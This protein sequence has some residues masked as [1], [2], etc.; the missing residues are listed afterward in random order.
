LDAL[1]SIRAGPAGAAVAIDVELVC[2]IHPYQFYLKLS[3]NPY[4]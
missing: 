1:S 4:P 3:E 2:I